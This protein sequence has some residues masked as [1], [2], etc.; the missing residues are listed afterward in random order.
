MLDVRAN[1]GVDSADGLVPFASTR[2]LNTV[3]QH[4]ALFYRSER[5]YLEELLPFITGAV[6]AGQPVL[7]AV[8][9]EELALLSAQLPD[10]IRTEV[11]LQDMTRVGRNPGALIMAYQRFLRDHGAGPARLV[12]QPVWAHRTGAEYAAAAEHEALCNTAF[13]AQ[14]VAIACPYDSRTLSADVLAEARCTHPFVRDEAGE[15]ASA[16]YAPH[17]VLARH[18]TPL[19]VPERAATRR[20]ATLADLPGLRR[21]TRI[22]FHTRAVA[23]GRVAD[24]ELVVS[25]LAANS[26]RHTSGGCQLALWIDGEDMVCSV[27]DHGQLTDPLAGRRLPAPEQTG[28]RGLLLVNELARLVRTHTSTSA[29]TIQV[30]L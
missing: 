27:T 20:A 5:E 17:Q 15:S 8:P 1:G 9:T 25:E 21:F 14:P 2:H 23:T 22:Y 26:L 13:L 3:P 18:N 7:V 28:G 24:I 30:R 4:T 12:G 19:A 29:T 6:A 16:Q 11:S 10:S